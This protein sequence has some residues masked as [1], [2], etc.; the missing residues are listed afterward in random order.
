MNPPQNT[1]GRHIGLDYGTARIG[2]AISD[3]S[4]RIVTPVTTLRGTGSLEQDVRQ[5][6]RYSQ[7]ERPAAIVIGLP[8]NMDGTDSEQTTLTRK[9]IGLLTESAD[10]R[11]EAWDERLSTFQANALM[12]EAGVP[13]QERKNYRDQ[14]AA[15]VIL[16]SYLAA[17]EADADELEREAKEMEP[18]PESESGST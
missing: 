10:C 7:E 15:L 13:R 8:L 2:V 17:K 3:P 16:R 1:P 6:L 5:V 4:G 11:I 14:F 9:F 18:D 12:D